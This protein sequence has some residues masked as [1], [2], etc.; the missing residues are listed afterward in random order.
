MGRLQNAESRA[1]QGLLAV[2]SAVMRSL[3]IMPRTA[4]TAA[5]GKSQSGKRKVVVILR[6]RGGNSLPA[7]SSARVGKGTTLDADEA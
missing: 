5:P 3:Q 7:L 2:I 4:E 6:E 1:L